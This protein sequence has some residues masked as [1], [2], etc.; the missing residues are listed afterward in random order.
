MHED[1][2]FSE[3]STILTED[4]E[5]RLFTNFLNLILMYMQPTDLENLKKLTDML[6]S[7]T[8][9]TQTTS[10]C[11][12]DDICI[13]MKALDELNNF[14]NQVDMYENPILINGRK[15]LILN[16][17]MS[18]QRYL[19]QKQLDRILQVLAEQQATS[20][21]LANELKN[22]MSKQFTELRNYYTQIE[23]FN[24]EIANADIQFIRGK[25]T[26]F[27]GSI[28]VVVGDFVNK[29]NKLLMLMVY[30][31]LQ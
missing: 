9:Y 5:E 7:P 23:N 27:Q 8:S 26:S 14:V 2:T 13:F 18:Y 31:F 21:A 24:A 29:M 11:Q 30:R 28:N 3:L 22:Q 19:Q 17:G 15:R 12:S 4:E 20:I 16:T 25:L 6:P 1:P 10:S